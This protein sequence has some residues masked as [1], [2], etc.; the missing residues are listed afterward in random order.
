MAGE[1]TATEEYL[2]LE[3]H[4]KY[5]ELMEQF[6]EIVRCRRSRKLIELVSIDHRI[7]F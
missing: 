5:V 4:K 3:V 2:M 1:D 6:G 7:H